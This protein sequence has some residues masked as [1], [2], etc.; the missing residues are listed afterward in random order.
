MVNAQPFQVTGVQPQPKRLGPNQG[1]LVMK[2]TPSPSSR[3]S[4]SAPV[5]AERAAPD[6]APVPIGYSPD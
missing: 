4:R 1:L 5:L 6:Q 2:G 3:S